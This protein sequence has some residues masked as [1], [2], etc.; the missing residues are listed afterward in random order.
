MH[1]SSGYSNVDIKGKNTTPEPGH[2]TFDLLLFMTFLLSVVV[3]EAM[4][5]RQKNQK[6]LKSESLNQFTF[7]VYESEKC[8]KSLRF[9]ILCAKVANVILTNTQ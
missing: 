2:K 6:I 4:F 7:E 9:W 5:W 3:F 8:V 1:P